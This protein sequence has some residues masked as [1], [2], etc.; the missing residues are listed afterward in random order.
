MLPRRRLALAVL[1]AVVGCAGDPPPAD[2]PPDGAAP[3]GTPLRLSLDVPPRVAAGDPVPIT[4]RLT[5]ASSRT[6]DLYLQGREIA[7]DIQIAD[8][9]G[10][11]LWRRMEGMVP[12]AI[13]QV[14]QLAPKESLE[15]EH[16]WDQ[17]RRGGGTVPPGVYTVVG[18]LLTESP[19]GIAFG[20]SRLEIVPR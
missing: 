11:V 20:P 12:Q 15:L 17:R 16:T 1:L 4:L 2:A 14:K 10:S 19:E 13:L 5:N 18:L 6:L 7:F 9:G 3:Q 8:A